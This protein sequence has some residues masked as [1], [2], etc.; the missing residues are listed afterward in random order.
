MPM[1][2]A[3]LVAA[4]HQVDHRTDEQRHEDGNPDPFE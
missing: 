2:D 1:W 4:L 3:A